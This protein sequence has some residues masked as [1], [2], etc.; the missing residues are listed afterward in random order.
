MLCGALAIVALVVKH[1]ETT[2]KKTETKKKWVDL[3]TT[4]RP[5]PGDGNS[6]A[7]AGSAAYMHALGG[8]SREAHS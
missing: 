2:S 6:A 1:H 8:G 7:S 4:E 3:S 5:S